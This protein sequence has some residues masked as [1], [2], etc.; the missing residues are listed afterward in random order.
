[1]FALIY[2]LILSRRQ[3]NS[4]PISFIDEILKHSNFIPFKTILGYLSDIV[5]N[6]MSTGPVL[7]L[8]GNL[9]ICFPLGVYLTVFLKKKSNFK[10]IL[11][12]S[13]FIIFILEFIQIILKRGHFDIDDLILNV[14][15]ACL[16]YL[17]L[18]NK[19]IINIIKY[20]FGKDFYESNRCI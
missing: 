12:S 10:F 2:I 8:L 19:Y 4:G 5:S 6:N 18:Q 1:M 7:N 15:G 20:I 3:F 13:T 17:I 16:G 11:I 14:M 9:M